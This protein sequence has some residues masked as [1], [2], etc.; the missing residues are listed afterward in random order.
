MPSAFPFIFLSSSFLPSLYPYPASALSSS[1]SFL[2]IPSTLYSFD[3]CITLS[4]HL[5]KMSESPPPKYQLLPLTENDSSSSSSV[6]QPSV[7]TDMATAVR[8][9]LQ[10]LV[11]SIL[12]VVPPIAII[13]ALSIK[14]SIPCPD[15]RL[16]LLF[17][18]FLCAFVTQAPGPLIDAG[19]EKFLFTAESQPRLHNAYHRWNRV[20][21]Y[22]VGT[23]LSTY[24]AHVI[25]FDCNV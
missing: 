5:P 23:A 18:N 24:L 10:F 19:V 11:I 16:P 25:K 4:S 20:V 22:Y 12:Y 14:P 13:I 21:L 6:T 17:S 8:P 15:A 9:S 3:S 7:N 1:S 2:P